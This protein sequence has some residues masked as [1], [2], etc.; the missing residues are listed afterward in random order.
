MANVLRGLS[1][2]T[3]E[4]YLGLAFLSHNTF[5]LN[6]VQ[7]AMTR[8]GFCPTCNG[9]VWIMFNLQYPLLYKPQ[10]TPVVQLTSTLITVPN[11][12]IQ[13]LLTN[14]SHVTLTSNHSHTI[15]FH[16]AFLNH[17]D[18]SQLLEVTTL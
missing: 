9:Q 8:C 18:I 7:P 4:P 14:L 13:H 2:P 12:L 1:P 17:G 11:S 6:Y 16:T 5:S 15:G 10:H 3:L